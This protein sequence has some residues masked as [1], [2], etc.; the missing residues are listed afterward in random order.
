[1]A[2]SSFAAWWFLPFV[3]PVCLYIAWTDLS[4]MKI[5]NKAVVVL[6]GIFVLIAPFVLADLPLYGWQLAQLVIMLVLGIVL[7]AAGVMGAG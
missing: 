1:M 4:R 2:L 3:V 7:N 5:T 6:T